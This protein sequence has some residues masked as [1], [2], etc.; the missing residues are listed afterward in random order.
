[1]LPLISSISLVDCDQRYQ[2]F[3][4]RPLVVRR[5]LQANPRKRSTKIKLVFRKG[6]V[7]HQR[8]LRTGLEFF[9][10]GYCISLRQ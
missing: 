6:S 10:I 9:L 3:C 4:L 2:P 5:R 8:T 7:L 1:M